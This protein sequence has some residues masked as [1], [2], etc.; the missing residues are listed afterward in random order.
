MSVLGANQLRDSSVVR[1]TVHASLAR[2]FGI[3]D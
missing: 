3:A 1:A 2:R